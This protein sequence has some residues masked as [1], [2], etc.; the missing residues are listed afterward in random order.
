M[1]GLVLAVA[2][3]G[4]ALGAVVLNRIIITVVEGLLL[5]VG[6]LLWRRRRAELQSA[7]VT[8]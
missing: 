7:P 8:P 5:L 2:P 1:Y 3:S 4:I 6:A